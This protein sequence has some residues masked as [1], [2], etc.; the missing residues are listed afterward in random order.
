M[1]PRSIWRGAISFG[2]VSIP[3]KLFTATDSKDV[4]FRQLHREDNARVRQL[5]WCS[6]EDKEIPLDEIVRGYE[7]AKDSY[8][9]L[10]AEDFDKLPLASRRTI[11][12]QAFVNAEEIDPVYYEKA[13]YLEPDEAGVKP[14]ALLLRALE[15]K[16]LTAIAQIAIRS[17]EQLCA[18]R[19]VD[20]RIMLET[21]HYPD[22][23]R[24]RELEPAETVDV[25]DEEMKMAFTLIEM[26]EQPFEPEQYK[27]AYRDALMEIISA[28]LEGQEVVQAE[29][30]ETAKVIDL[31]AALKASVKATKEKQ[32]APAKGAGGKRRKAAAS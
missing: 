20:G 7:Y 26:L 29:E 8:V 4:S 1:P 10:D 24:M 2:M 31:M 5:R 25:S 28:K 32:D 30:P 22:E 3:V 9:I 17:K 18:L 6:V 15:E 16:G 11:E 14:F 27:D 23:I 21:L 13:Y 12:L 19:P